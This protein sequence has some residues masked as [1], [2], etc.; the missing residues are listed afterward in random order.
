MAVVAGTKEA[1]VL[2]IVSTTSGAVRF[3]TDLKY[4]GQPVQTRGLAW[5]PDGRDIVFF[6]GSFRDRQDASGASVRI[7][8]RLYRTPTAGGDLEP[9]GLETSE[10]MRNLRSPQIRP[11]G[12]EIRFIATNTSPAPA[13][14]WVL[15]NFLPTS[16]AGR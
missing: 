5:T 2:N 14:V 13:A 10:E 4:R 8:V 6:G 12:R 7:P 1:P 3:V 16:E 9:V 15:E 11:D